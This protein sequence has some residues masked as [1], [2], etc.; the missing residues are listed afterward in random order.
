VPYILGLKAEVLRRNRINRLL[1][2][3]G[4]QNFDDKVDECSHLRS[5]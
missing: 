1:Q 2:S 3:I 5:R 4:I